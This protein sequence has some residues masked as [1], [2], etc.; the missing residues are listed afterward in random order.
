VVAKESLRDEGS[1]PSFPKRRFDVTHYFTKDLEFIEN[2]CRKSPK[3]KSLDSLSQLMV[4]R[5]IQATIFLR[6]GH[7]NVPFG[8]GYIRVILKY[9]LTPEKM[10]DP[11]IRKEKKKYEEEKKWNVKRHSL[12][13]RLVIDEP[14][15]QEEEE[16][17]EK[18]I[19]E[20]SQ[21][22]AKLPEH[23]QYAIRKRYYLKIPL[24]DSERGYCHRALVH[25][26]KKSNSQTI[27]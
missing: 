26:R 13:D 7:K 10:G 19:H 25:L 20:I 5:N 18:Q 14:P 11:L 2:V 23:E 1:Q 17:K 8:E 24:T 6:K 3:F 27:D 12:E 9:A 15:P 22:L 4:L 21:K 16:S